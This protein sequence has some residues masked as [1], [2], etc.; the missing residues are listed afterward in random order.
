MR[1]ER[2][3]AI[4]APHEWVRTIT[5][6][7]VGGW[8]VHPGI[9]VVPERAKVLQWLQA[10]YLLAPDIPGRIYCYALADPSCPC[11]ELMLAPAVG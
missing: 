1:L 10:A 6:L 4:K 2:A 5:W 7:G 9:R 8:F 3:K 11:R